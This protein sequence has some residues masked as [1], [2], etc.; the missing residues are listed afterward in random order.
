MEKDSEKKIG[1]GQESYLIQ[2]LHKDDRKIRPD[3]VV[4][5]LVI[6]L[7][8]CVFMAYKTGYKQGMTDE[9]ILWLETKE[10]QRK[11]KVDGK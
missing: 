7:V 11:D 3:T 5:I 9:K 4:Q 10:L 1:M 2:A 6:M 8:A